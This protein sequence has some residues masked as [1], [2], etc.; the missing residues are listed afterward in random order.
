MVLGSLAGREASGFARPLS[1]YILVYIKS[2]DLTYRNSSDVIVQKSFLTYEL[3]G[4]VSEIGNQFSDNNL[5]Y[6]TFG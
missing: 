6:R 3:T 4:N 1:C 5:S 2:F